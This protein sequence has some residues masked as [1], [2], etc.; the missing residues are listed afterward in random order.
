[1]SEPDSTKEMTLDGRMEIDILLNEKI[2][3]LKAQKE[4]NR[5][6]IL[7][8]LALEDITEQTTNIAR[9][10]YKTQI[11]RTLDKDL[12]EEFLEGYNKTLDEF[13]TDNESQILRIIA[14]K[15]A[16]EE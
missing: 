11:R 2:R 7:T 6:H 13:K 10:T 5:T 9:L 1:M 3:S 14:N 4:N 16:E 12:I 8:I 15:I